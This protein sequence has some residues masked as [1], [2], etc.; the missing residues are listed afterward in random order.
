MR[1]FRSLWL[2]AALLLVLTLTIACTPDDPATE[3]DGGTLTESVTDAPT[4]ESTDGATEPPTEAP[5]EDPTEAPTEAPTESPTEAPTEP[6]ETLP[7]DEDVVVAAPH[8]LTFSPSVTVKQ[9]GGTA[10][11]THGDGLSYTATGFAGINGGKLTFTKGL[12]LQFDP[13]DTA[14]KFNRFTLGYTS[15]QPLY[16]KVTYTLGGSAVTDDFYLEAGTGTFSCLISRYLN[17]MTGSSIASMTFETCNGKSA[18]FALCVLKT[19]KY[20][21]YG[22]GADTYYIENLRYKLGV[23]LIW[24]GGVNYLED[25]LCGITRLTNLVNQADTGRLIQQS[26][27]GVMENSEYKPGF[28]NG[29]KWCYNPVQG[30]DVKGNHSRIIDIVVTDYSVY[31]KSQPMDWSKDGEI[32]PSYMENT[33]TLYGD[34]VQVGNRFTDFSGWTHRMTSQEVPAFYTISYLSSFSFYNGT[35]PWTGDTLSYRD[36]LNFW[37]DS[38]WHGDCTFRLRKSNT[39]TWCAWT[40][41]KDDFGIGLYVPNVDSFLAGRHAFNNSRESTNG[42]TNYVAP[43]NFILIKSF[44]S[45]EY[46]YLITTG[47]LSEIRSTFTEH[48]SFATNASLDKNGQDYRIPDNAAVTNEYYY[49]SQEDST[50]SGPA[51]KLSAVLDLTKPGNAAHVV[52]SHSTAVSYD[53][54]VGALCLK[55]TGDDP[56]VTV[57]Y[58]GILSADRYKTLEITYM[59]PASNSKGNNTTDL[60]L[61]AGAVLNPDPNASVRVSN[62]PDGQYHVMTIDLAGQAFWQGDIHKIRLDYLDGCAAGDVVYVKSIVLK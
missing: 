38:T 42:A 41:P 25:K 9:N 18:D 59:I 15:T 1:R 2:L 28:Y 19:E 58:D 6:E 23:R 40:N 53:A 14:E 61:C 3:T 43:V 47:S 32:T 17:R 29:S 37:G 31:V 30:G 51:D 62:T 27:Y 13:A 36:D 49:G 45:L 56:N 4:E 34:R 26:Y 7:P 33:Y 50:P 57:V 52:A 55:V 20:P 39:E 54:N 12:T 24:G 11:V 46:S 5:T 60:F 21:V 44:E 22:E 35:K 8:K 10:T 16:G 48:K